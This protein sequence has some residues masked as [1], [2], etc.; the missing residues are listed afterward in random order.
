[1]HIYVRVLSHL[2]DYN[3]TLDQRA[4]RA[5]SPGSSHSPRLRELE[6]HLDTTIGEDS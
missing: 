5:S 3:K 1:M 6:K 4:V 2:G